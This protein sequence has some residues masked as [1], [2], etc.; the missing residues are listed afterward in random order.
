MPQSL[1]ADLHLELPSAVAAE[2]RWAFTPPRSWLAGVVANLGLAALWLLVPPLHPHHHHDWVILIGTY[3]SSFILAD[4]TTTNLLGIDHIRVGEALDDGVPLWRILL[5]KN[6]TLV[7]IVGVPTLAVAVG[8]T[9]WLETPARLAIT[10]PD[11]A[12]PIVSWL[13]VGNLVSVLLPVGDQ[14]LVA[15]WRQRRDRRA[16]LKW[17]AHLALPYLL[18]YVADPVGGVEHKFLWRE[19]PRAVA[20]ILGRESRSF[21]HI[22]IAFAVWAVTTALALLFFSGRGLHIAES[23][24]DEGRTSVAA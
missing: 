18:Y 20:S 14:P 1:P 9:L 3:F 23:D 6:L 16:T 24:R 22:G 17:I 4:V 7:V 15:R 13:G 8:M 12:V 2:V 10:V 5:V 11:V 21:V 19:V